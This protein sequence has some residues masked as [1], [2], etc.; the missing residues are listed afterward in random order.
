MQRFHDNA[1]GSTA[2]VNYNGTYYYYVRNGQNDIIRL[3]DGES[4]TVVEYAYD[5]WGRQISC[6]GSL[7]STLGAQNPFRYRAY[8]YDAE[9]GFY[10]LQ[11]RYYDPTVGRFISADVF[12]STGQGV[13]GHNA[14]SYCGDNPVSRID[15]NGASWED[16]WEWLKSLFGGGNNCAG[17]GRDVETTMETTA[18]TTTPTAVAIPTPSPNPQEQAVAIA[19]EYGA[20][21][22]ALK[23]INKA[24]GN[25]GAPYQSPPKDEGTYDCASLVYEAARTID[26]SFSGGS[27][28]KQRKYF[29]G[30][31]GKN[32]WTFHDAEDS[33]KKE[34]EI[35]MPGDLI[36][37]KGSGS[38][39]HVAIYLG[40]EYI[41]DATISGGG[42]AFRPFFGYTN[43]NPDAKYSGFARFIG[44]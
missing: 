36:Y 24:A 30:E 42:V 20:T 27:C 18:I 14:Y 29:S 39:G 34:M 6:T 31:I 10:Y 40:G 44:Q 23:M 38:H 15:C 21:S 32:R 11:S 2:V 7:A 5:S 3:I 33:L 4:N 43:D 37:W 26:N 25:I 35:M 9:T 8:V 12:L 1:S 28:R 22:E 13:L 19:K 16:F 17:N 41:L